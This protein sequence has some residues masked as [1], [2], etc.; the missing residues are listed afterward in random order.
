MKLHAKKFGL[1]LGII[2]G[3]SVLVLTLISAWTDFGYLT[4]TNLS[5]YPGYSITVGG[6]F[7]GGIWAF[8]DGFV[9]GTLIIWVYNKLVG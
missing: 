7:I 3:L 1:A 8:I 6:A 5:I 9:G 2:W 4:L